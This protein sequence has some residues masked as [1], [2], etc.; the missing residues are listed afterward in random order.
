MI[1]FSSRASAQSAA[2]EPEHKSPILA[3]LISLVVP[4]LG[5]AYANRFEA[6]RYLVGSEAILWGGYAGLAVYTSDFQNDMENYAIA[7]AG[8]SAG[9]K[10]DQNYFAHVGQ[11]Q[12]SDLFNE[13]ML[14]EGMASNLIANGQGWSWAV[15]SDQ[16][17]FGQLR[18][19]VQTLDND[20]QFM[21]AAIV[22]NHLISAI[23]AY[24]V[25][26]N[27]NRDHAAPPAQGMR[28]EVGGHLGALYDAKG[29]SISA[30]LTF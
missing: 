2:T 21:L 5:E 13:E 29:A 8:A 7:R 10:G 14:R 18:T 30:R 22:V 16:L 23:D 20:R 9:S 15:K 3:A 6:G 1:G 24:I 25:T 26:R 4:G 12:S 27:F 17:Y 28:L 11:Y 19:K